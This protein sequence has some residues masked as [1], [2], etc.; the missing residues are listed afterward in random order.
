MR[1]VWKPLLCVTLCV[2]LLL[3]VTG[4][5]T[6]AAQD[7]MMGISP[8]E[9]NAMENMS[10]YNA[11]VTDFA[12][13][14][15]RAARTEDNTL[16]SPLSALCAL[17]LTVNGAEGDTLTQMEQV[18]GMT[19]DEIN[20]YLHTYLASLKEEKGTV[21]PANALWFT[22]DARFAVDRD[23]L[24]TNADYH[25]ADAYQAPFNR[26][27]VEDINAW[28][29]EKTDSRITRMLEEIPREAVMYLVNAL[30]F[31]SKWS[32]PYLEHQVHDGSFYDGDGV[33]H[34]V[35]LMYGSESAYI[36]D[37]KAIGFMKTYQGGR[38]AFAALLPRENEITLDEYV[39][40]LDGTRLHTLL[41]H[42][43]Y[44]TVHTAIPQFTVE[45]DCQLEKP[46]Q[47]MGMPL[48]FDEDKAD[49]SRLGRSAAGNIYVSRVLHKTAITVGEQ[50]T[51]AGAATAVEMLDK[52]AAYI[53]DPV[54]IYLTRPFVYMLVDCTTYTPIFIGAMDTP[55]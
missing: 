30:T 54:Q 35:P 28:V 39:H 48:A 32:K 1:R 16:L 41:S 52:S 33:E 5:A 42:P 11:K 21:L 25:G 44:R 7:L 19:A 12:V 4:C 47:S 31:E 45:S 53:E 27:T 14:L 18:L 38:Y 40:S 51:K 24:Q 2:T 10:T 3:S 15:F 17:G 29:K 46:L 9:V 6:V 49:F 26:Q 23:F 34:T 50:G 55:V 43:Q 22:A 37:E 36:E 13:R 20:R 8:R